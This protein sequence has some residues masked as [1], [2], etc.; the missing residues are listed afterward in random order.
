MQRGASPQTV[1][2]Q[3]EDAAESFGQGL[4]INS[5]TVSHQDGYTLSGSS[6]R[7]WNHE[8]CVSIT[9]NVPPVSLQV[10]LK[11]P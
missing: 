5:W 11:M 9:E 3:R 6:E 4:V 2:P 7:V 10:S 1:E 8:A